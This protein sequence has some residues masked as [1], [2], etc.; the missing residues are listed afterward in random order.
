MAGLRFEGTSFAGCNILRRTCWKR[1]RRL[2]EQ[3]VLLLFQIARSEQPRRQGDE[4]FPDHS[5]RIVS[6]YRETSN[7]QGT[8]RIETTLLCA[9]HRII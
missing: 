5:A 8:T 9:F 7:Q 6:K 3:L 2:H 1:P 4:C